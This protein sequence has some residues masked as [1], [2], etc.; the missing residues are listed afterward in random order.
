MI[1]PISSGMNFLG[2][3]SID[4]SVRKSVKALPKEMRKDV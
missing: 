3:V 4:K 2:R 1:Q